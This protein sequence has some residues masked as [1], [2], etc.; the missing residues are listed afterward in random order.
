MTYHVPQPLRDTDGHIRFYYLR[1][2]Q[3]Y[4]MTLMLKIASRHCLE[5]L[6]RGFAP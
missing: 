1:S 5:E 3:R 2:S 6:L 4:N